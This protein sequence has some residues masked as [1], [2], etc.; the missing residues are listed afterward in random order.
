MLPFTSSASTIK[1]PF[2]DPD[3]RPGN[4]DK[5]GSMRAGRTEHNGPFHIKILLFSAIPF[6]MCIT[7]FRK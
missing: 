2:Q 3:G 1:V 5:P 6:Q 4:A 7:I